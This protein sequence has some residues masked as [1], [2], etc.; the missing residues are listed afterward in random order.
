[1]AKN[2]AT[3]GVSGEVLHT[4]T[5]ADAAESQVVV[6]GTDGSDVVLDPATLATQA[7]AAAVLAKLPATPALDGSDVTTPTAM[8]AGG[9]GIR[10]WLSAIWTKLNGSLA[11]T[12]TFFQATQPVSAAALPLP[13]GAAQEHATAASP[14]SVRLSDG[15]AYLATLPVSGTVAVSSAP[16]TAVTAAALPLPTG[17]ATD[18]T[19]AA[20]TTKMGD[21]SQLTKKTPL[22]S[23]TVAAVASSVTVVS[24]QAANAA[25]RALKVY[26][27]S[28]AV[29]YLKDGAAAS[30]TDYSVQVASGGYYEWP[31]PIY[32]GAVTG[33]WSAAN[34]SA[35][36]TEGA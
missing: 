25:R 13:T 1:M 12:G 26:N 2:T 36:V 5:S 34:G 16:T 11:V 23:N 15:A 35:R 3:T 22:A 6:I 10:G 27:D 32:T 24:L 28:T 33:L 19:V 7:T 9:V 20:V 17:A 8:P 29:L 21:G 30:T 14:G 4:R 18:A 31:L